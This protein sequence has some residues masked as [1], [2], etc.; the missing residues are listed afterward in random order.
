M[1]NIDGKYEER[2]MGEKQRRW[3][4]YKCLTLN[5]LGYSGLEFETNWGKVD[6]A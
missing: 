5:A 1:N 6:Q 2:L 3:A 4:S